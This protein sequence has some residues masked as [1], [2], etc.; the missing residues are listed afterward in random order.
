ME[1][2]LRLQGYHTPTAFWIPSEVPGEIVPNTRFA[3]R[4]VGPTQA[5]MPRSVRIQEHPTDQR[6]RI[7]VFGE[8]AALGDPEPAFG[9]SRCLEALLE[10]R[11]GG[12][13]VEVINT[14]ITALN[15]FAFR[16]AARDSRR[17]RAD[18][19]V[20]YAGNNEVVG[21]F[22]PASMNG[23]SRLGLATT[24]LGLRFRETALG[25]WFTERQSAQ[26]EGLSLAQR[27]VGME[28]FLDRQLSWDDPRLPAMRENFRA[29]LRDVIELGLGAGA[30]VVLSTM[31][32]NL[33]DCP[34]FGSASTRSTNAPIFSQWAAA[35]T[36]ARAEDER[37]AVTEA[38]AAW[39]NAASLWP[40]DAET[41]YRLGL[42]HLNA[43]N[44][45][46]GRAD[47]E[48]ARDLDTLRFRADSQINQV[49]RDLA[50]EFASR[51]VRF[52]DADRELRGTDPDRHSRG[53][54]RR[55]RFAGSAR[56]L[57]TIPRHRD[58][59]GFPGM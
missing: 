31:A 25:Q 7:V 56:R 27:W 35:A 40:E 37:G 48:L 12:R 59:P 5:R 36:S 30:Q 55:G 54:V 19:W 20:V 45:P 44:L 39:T 8:S 1:A 29:N 46:T 41:R 43:G 11:L 18:F 38:V 57:W 32:V 17:L 4:F 26:G 13:P 42:A 14:S 21:P 52:V 9:M 6:L 51:S 15:S 22:G 34:P 50:Q 23:G 10:N 49:T 28:Q 58:P 3:E 33:L 47:L 53:R 16:E 2:I 24:R